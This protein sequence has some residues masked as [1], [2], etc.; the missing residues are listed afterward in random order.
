VSG[1]NG[2]E[3]RG[4]YLTFVVLVQFHDVEVMRIPALA[5]GSHLGRF[6]L[7][8]HR[9]PIRSPHHVPTADRGTSRVVLAAELDAAPVAILPKLGCAF[10]QALEPIVGAVFSN[11]AIRDPRAG[12]AGFTALA[13][14]ARLIEQFL[15]AEQVCVV[16]AGWESLDIGRV[17]GNHKG[18]ETP[19]QCR[20]RRAG[21]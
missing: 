13:V 10:T 3:G 8:R 7:E 18:V 14:E 16:G 1:K 11:A 20:R 2:E 6:V 4:C 12:R 21:I 15:Q 19:Q 17:L 5:A 9:Q